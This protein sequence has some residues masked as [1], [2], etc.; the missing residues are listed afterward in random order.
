MLAVA[1]SST[2]SQNIKRLRFDL[3]YLRTGSIY[4][5]HGSRLNYHNDFP[6]DEKVIMSYV[7]RIET[8]MRAA[9]LMNILKV[10]KGL[11]VLVSWK[12]LTSLEPLAIV[13]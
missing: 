6:L 8:R 13:Y 3:E 1:R 9:R 11:N 12:G 2:H 4:P 7:R 5:L 10:G